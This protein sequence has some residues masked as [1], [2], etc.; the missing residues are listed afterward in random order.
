MIHISGTDY[1]IKLFYIWSDERPIC[2][3]LHYIFQHKKSYL[4]SSQ[5]SHRRPFLERIQSKNCF[6]FWVCLLQKKKKPFK[7]FLLFLS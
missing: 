5:Q 6:V 3:S 2:K 4:S 7:K 1:N